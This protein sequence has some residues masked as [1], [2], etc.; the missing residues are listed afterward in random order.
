MD[1]KLGLLLPIK[2]DSR[3]ILLSS[4]LKPV[5]ELPP[6]PH[7]FSVD[8]TLHGIEDSRTFNNLQYGDCVIAQQAHAILRHEKYEQGIQISITD[9]EVVKE[10][11]RQTGNKDTGLYMQLAMKEWR[12]HGIKIG[13]HSY[14]IYAFAQ[15]DK[16]NLSQVKYSIYLLRGICFGAMLFESDL[17]QFRTGEPWHLTSNSGDF[18]GGHGLYAYTYNDT[19][20]ELEC[21]TWGRRQVLTYDWWL[22]RVQEAYAVVDNRDIWI[23][24]SPVNVEEL[25]R[26]L[27]EITGDDTEICSISRKIK[28][29]FT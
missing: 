25:N 15:T 29:W 19:N 17:E 26:Q 6:L 14:T 22:A 20:R 24:D 3:N 8:S 11:F 16:F 10:Y 1:L 23:P 18:V 21:M 13:G 7:I 27:S 28:R 5:E 12:N 2:K 4:I 9:E